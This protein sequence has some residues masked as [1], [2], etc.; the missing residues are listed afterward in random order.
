[1]KKLFTIIAIAMI[2]FT[3]Q[4]QIIVN[5]QDISNSE[6]IEIWAF[7][8]PFTMKDVYFADYGQDKFR[9]NMYD[10]KKQRIRGIE[11]GEGIKLLQ[12]M[13]HAGYKKTEER[14]DKIGNIQGRVMTFKK[15]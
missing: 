11:K 8:K 9:P 13:K 5:G 6:I 15:E 7:K 14:V 1:M 3:A 4:S 10:S 2:T 12:L